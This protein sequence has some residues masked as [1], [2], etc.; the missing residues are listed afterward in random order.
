M[1][2]RRAVTLNQLPQI[3]SIVSYINTTTRFNALF[4]SEFMCGLFLAILNSQNRIVLWS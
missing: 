1:E 4:R 3:V 2:P